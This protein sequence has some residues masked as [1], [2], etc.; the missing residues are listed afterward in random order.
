MKQVKRV[1]ALVLAG[2]LTLTG[3][4]A[5]NGVAYAKTCTSTIK[6]TGAD[7]INRSTKSMEYVKAMG[8]GWNLGNSMDS[9]LTDESEPDR[10][11]E[12]WGNPKVTKKYPDSAYILS[13]IHRK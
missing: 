13:E 8:A 9:I 6:G 5:G 10:G 1:C 4:F 12:S 11:E 7:R 3:L 2:A